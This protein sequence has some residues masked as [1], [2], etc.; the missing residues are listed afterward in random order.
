MLRGPRALKLRPH[1]GGILDARKVVYPQVAPSPRG[2]PARSAV[3]VPSG[4]TPI[5]ELPR[6]PRGSRALELRPHFGATSYVPRVARLASLWGVLREC[7][8]K[9]LAAGEGHFVSSGGPAGEYL[10]NCGRWR[11]A[12]QRLRATRG[13]GRLA[14]SGDSCE[15]VPRK[16]WP[17]ARGIS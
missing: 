13:K 14:S 11:V 4:C 17:L 9:K 16:S 3:R 15:G 6:M 8:S 7:T 5:L 1:F 12:T 10:E 2:Y